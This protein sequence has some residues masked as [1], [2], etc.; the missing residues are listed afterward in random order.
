MFDSQTSDFLD[1]LNTTLSSTP[2]SLFEGM[3]NEPNPL[4]MVVGLPRS[5]TTLAMQILAAGLNVNYFD[6]LSARFWKSPLHGLALSASAKI[7]GK[8]ITFNSEY[9]RTTSLGEPHEFS[10]FWKDILN[11]IPFESYDSRKLQ[12]EIDWEKCKSTLKEISGFE[13]CPFLFKA[14]HLAKYLN[15]W[16]SLYNDIFVV[17]ITRDIEDICHSMLKARETRS[18]GKNKWW[19][20]LP[21]DQ[22]KI[23][24]LPYYEQIPQQLTML[25]SDFEKGSS[26]IPKNKVLE[27][28]YEQLCAEP[29][30]MLNEVAS[31]MN[32]L[33]SRSCLKENFK[34]LV[35][36]NFNVK[37]NTENK[38]QKMVEA[39]Q[40]LISQ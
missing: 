14:I 5:G 15:K 8:A 27:I 23:K 22:S 35:P 11:Y 25:S 13:N 9:G 2:K 37:K 3:I 18:G 31:R 30:Y 1:K 39:I 24:D 4:I 29:H 38:D 7:K 10:Y 17:K 40:N 12:D 6:N 28:N 32:K 33:Y 36:S 20:L 34:E 26:E 21:N 16:H 19:S